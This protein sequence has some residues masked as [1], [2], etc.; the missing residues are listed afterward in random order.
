MN[1]N[2]RAVF[3]LS[4]CLAIA[5]FAGLALPDTTA[6]AEKDRKVISLPDPQKTGG[7]PLMSALNE[8]KTNRNIS[9]DKISEQ[10]LSNLLWAAWGINRNDGKRTAPT[11][12]NKQNVEVYAAIESGVWLYDAKK[13]ELLS[14]TENDERGKF[15]GAA[16]T[17]LY[18]APSNDPYSA[19]HIGSL[20]QSA[21]LYC[22]SA[23]LANV[24]KAGGR[25]ALNDSLKLPKGYEVFVVQL[26]GY[27]K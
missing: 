9:S 20:Y 5:F 17:L 7:K 24:V 19:M 6:A 13:N 22:A 23:G 4:L 14:V 8:R 11:A 21:G 25:N 12:M 3:N 26:V 16:V 10:E 27:P 2:L 18:A 15:S 1:S